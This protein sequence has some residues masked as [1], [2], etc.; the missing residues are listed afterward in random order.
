MSRL[1]LLLILHVV[2]FSSFGQTVVDLQP[3][4]KQHV[5]G[6]YVPFDI[7]ARGNTVYFEIESGHFPGA[8]LRLESSRPYFLFLNG[9]LAGE[10]SGAISFPIDSL[11]GRYS[12]SLVAGIFQTPINPRELKTLVIKRETRLAELVP[13]HRP[14]SSFKDFVIVSGLVIIIFFLVVSQINP[15]L[16]ADYFSV[17][18]IF[19][20]READDAQSNARLTSSNNFQFYIGCSFLLALYLLI[21]LYHLPDDYALPL[22]FRATDFW[23]IVLQWMRL[24]VL[25]LLAFIGKIVIVFMLTRLFNMRGLAR[26]HFFN[27]MRLI[28]IVFGAATM[29]VFSYYIL[30]GQNATVFVTFL[31]LIIVTLIA[32]IFII[33]MKL[34]GKTEHS[35]FHLFSYICATELIPLLIT[36]KVLFQ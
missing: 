21:I 8:S 15:K 23:S 7:D 16:A 3:S 2:A 9:K 34:N 18:K 32:W 24:S 20:P 13:I 29:L 19:S 30:R 28:L 36:V 11:A 26:V 10:F 5:D 12:T 31:S 35:M 33:F 4:W 6:E 27:W 17:V 1:L 22:K 14:S 25:V